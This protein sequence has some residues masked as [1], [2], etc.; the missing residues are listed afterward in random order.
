MRH[1]IYIPFVNAT[2]YST[3]ALGTFPS[4]T[5]T[6]NW[7]MMVLFHSFC[8]ILVLFVKLSYWRCLKDYVFL[9]ILKSSTVILIH[10]GL[11]RDDKCRLSRH[12]MGSGFLNRWFLFAGSVRTD[13]EV[14]DY[15]W[16]II[17]I[18]MNLGYVR[19][20]SVDLRYLKRLDECWIDWGAVRFRF[21]G[22]ILIR[23]IEFGIWV[24]HGW[25]LLC[26]QSH[27]IRPVYC[28]CFFLLLTLNACTA[29]AA[30]L[31]V[32]RLI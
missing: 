8:L 26:T 22:N 16:H 1:G 2:T 23:P 9:G 4:L 3:A 17:L 31:K 20:L 25:L 15:L 14:S 27:S 29:D 30:N 19:A 21:N 11:F 18:C 6:A 28:R 24:V 10:K 32:L 5:T 12:Q 7:G 13:R